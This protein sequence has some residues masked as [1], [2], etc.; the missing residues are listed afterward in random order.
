[1]K[2]I[3]LIAL[4]IIISTSVD[5]QGEE[6][7]AKKLAYTVRNSEVWCEQL[8]GVDL[9]KEFHTQHISYDDAAIRV[10]FVHK[11]RQGFLKQSFK[12]LFNDKVDLKGMVEKEIARLEMI[13]VWIEGD[14]LHMRNTLFLVD[15][16]LNIDRFNDTV[17][18]YK[19]KLAAYRDS[20]A[21]QGVGSSEYCLYGT[22]NSYFKSIVIEGEKRSVQIPLDFHRKQAIEEQR[23]K[24]PR[25]VALYR[26]VRAA[27]NGDYVTA[28]REAQQAAQDG[29]A[30]AQYQLAYFYAH[31]LGVKK[32]KK[33]A[34]EWY[35]K[36]AQQGYEPAQFNLCGSDSSK[37][38]AAFAEMV[39]SRV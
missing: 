19:K 18:H 30:V 22:I 27:E 38:A 31:G 12:E 3:L 2:H 13:A 9:R 28:F 23:R 17:E 35:T 37:L 39:W 14:N 25:V 7:I 1:M 32:D 5:A 33:A 8:K 26:A 4:L 6:S 16:Q 29:N 34:I 11:F 10:D 21:A 20:K 24:A 36:S 15:P